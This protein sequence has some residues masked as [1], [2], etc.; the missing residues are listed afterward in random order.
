MRWAKVG[1]N[2][3]A[4]PIFLLRL[5]LPH[6]IVQVVEVHPDDGS[7]RGPRIGCS[8]KL[9]NQTDGVDLDPQVWAVQTITRVLDVLGFGGLA[10]QMVLILTL[11]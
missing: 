2:Y 1:Q 4:C 11:R 10:K 6:V 9:V 8:L 3:N 5:L 7:G